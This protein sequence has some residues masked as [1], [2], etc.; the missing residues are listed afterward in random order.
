MGAELAGP[1]TEPETRTETGTAALRV[2]DL[3]VQAAAG[4]V[5]VSGVDLD[6]PSGATASADAGIAPKR[7]CSSRS[8]SYRRVRELHFDHALRE[9]LSLAG[10]PAPA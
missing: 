9:P 3:T 2:R 7:P 8:L 5:I 1:D 4:T 6:L 10:A